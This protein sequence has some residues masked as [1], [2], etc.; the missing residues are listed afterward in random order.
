MRPYLDLMRRILESGTAKGDRTGTRSR[1]GEQ[2]RFD[3][4]AGLL[5][6]TR[7]RSAPGWDERRAAVVP[8]RGQHPALTRSGQQSQPRPWPPGARLS[9]R[10]PQDRSDRRGGDQ[11]DPARS[12]L[13]AHRG[14]RLERRGARGD[15]LGA[16]P[17]ATACPHRRWPVPP[18]SRH[19]ATTLRGGPF[20][21][22]GCIKSSERTVPLLPA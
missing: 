8:A 20:V 11:A 4:A 21:G 7:E 2:L 14:E 1:F 3:L 13:P 12:A 6:V 5:V 15:V 9:G 10:R 16:L 22:H 17:C 18:R 19:H